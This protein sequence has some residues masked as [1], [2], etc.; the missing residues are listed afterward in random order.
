MCILNSNHTSQTI[1]IWKKTEKWLSSFK[2]AKLTW[3]IALIKFKG[4]KKWVKFNRSYTTKRGLKIQST[5]FLSSIYSSSSVILLSN[6]LRDL[7]VWLWRLLYSYYLLNGF[8]GFPP[9]NSKRFIDEI[10]FFLKKKDRFIERN[11]VS[12]SEFIWIFLCLLSR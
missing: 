3:Q 10:R 8:W 1:K 11:C 9:L 2:E 12:T 5:S 4:I 6:L 7:R